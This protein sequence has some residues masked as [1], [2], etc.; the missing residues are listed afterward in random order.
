MAEIVDG[1]TVAFE[2][3]NRFDEYGLGFD[4][5][6]TEIGDPGTP[7]IGFFANALLVWVSCQ[8]NAGFDPHVHAAAIAFCVPDHLIKL[9]ADWHPYLYTEDGHL[10]MDGV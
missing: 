5:D 4:N 6:G 8:R 9:A 3:F 10:E 7:G 2:R 1:R